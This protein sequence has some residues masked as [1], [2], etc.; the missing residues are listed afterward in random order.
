MAKKRMN[1]GGWKVRNRWGREDRSGQ[2]DLFAA[3][4]D[5]E[6][7]AGENRAVAAAGGCCRVS[8]VG[9]AVGGE[10][11]S[12]AQ[13]DRNRVSFDLALREHRRDLVEVIKHLIDLRVL[14]RVDGDEQ[15]FLAS[16]DQDVL[17]NVNGAALAAMLNV[18]RRPSTMA[19]RSTEARIN[20]IVD[21]PFPAP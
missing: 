1:R 4:S 18:R 5:I 11:A 7:L 10:F 17:Y 13:L 16:P 20:A 15:Y 8:R 6:Q 9:D 12:D 21:E 14:T 3:A 2:G 19:A